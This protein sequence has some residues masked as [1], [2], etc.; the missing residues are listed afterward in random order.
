M[1]GRQAGALPL[2]PLYQSEPSIFSAKITFKIT[3]WRM[4]NIIFFQY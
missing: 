4:R 2:E 3:L 1:I